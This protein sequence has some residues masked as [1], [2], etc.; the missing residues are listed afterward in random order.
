MTHRVTT[1]IVP[2][3]VEMTTGEL[4]GLTCCSPKLMSEQTGR[5][6]RYGLSGTREPSLTF[7]VRSATLYIKGFLHFG[8]NDMLCAPSYESH[9]YCFALN[10]KEIPRLRSG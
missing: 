5:F 8:R 9:N 2:R 3:S 4:F 10:A 7:A 1:R 6:S